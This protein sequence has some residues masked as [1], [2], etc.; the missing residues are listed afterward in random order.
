MGRFLSNQGR[1][2][3]GTSNLHDA[4][5]GAKETDLGFDYRIPVYDEDPLLIPTLRNFVPSPDQHICHATIVRWNRL[6]RSARPT[7]DE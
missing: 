5:G 7:L 3:A 1:Y 6:I 2:R 4:Q